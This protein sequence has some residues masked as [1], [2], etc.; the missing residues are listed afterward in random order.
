MYAIIAS[1]YVTVLVGIF[2][3][4]FLVTD[5]TPLHFSRTVRRLFWYLLSAIFCV[6][7]VM[8]L[9]HLDLESSRFFGLLLLSVVIASYA[10]DEIQN[11]YYLTPFPVK[12]ATDVP[13]T[14]EAQGKADYVSSLVA[15]INHRKGFTAGLSQVLARAAGSLSKRRTA[16]H[17][18]LAE[19]ETEELN[20]IVLNIN[21]SALAEVVSRP[22]MDM[23]TGSD[24]RLP[25]LHVLA[26][27]ALLDAL[28]KVGMRWRPMRQRWASN[29][30]LSTHGRELTRL[31]SYVDDGDDYQTLYKM[32]YNDFQGEAQRS[33]LQ[34]ISTQGQQ[35]LQE[36]HAVAPTAPPGVCLKVVSDIDDTLM[37]SG[38]TWPAGRDM[39]Y[40]RKCMYPGALALYSELD[41][42]YCTR[43][44]QCKRLEKKR[45]RQASGSLSDSDKMQS[46]A[47][48]E[49]GYLSKL[50]RSISSLRHSRRDTVDGEQVKRANSVE[51]IPEE[52]EDAL[53]RGFFGLFD[54]VDS[55]MGRHRHSRRPATPVTLDQRRSGHI[56]SRS[57]SNLPK[58]MQGSGILGTTAGEEVGLSGLPDR[59]SVVQLLDFGR[60]A[61]QLTTS[62]AGAFPD[63]EAR[64][65]ALSSVSRAFVGSLHHA[66]QAVLHP[67][68]SIQLLAGPQQDPW[69]A[70]AGD[71]SAQKATEEEDEEEP[72][73]LHQAG[74]H[75]AFLSARPESV[76][77]LTEAESFKNIFNPLLKRGELYC[78]PVL[79]LGSIHSGPTALLRFM[80]GNRPPRDNPRTLNTQLNAA[81][82]NR[83]LSRFK[84]FA[85]LYPE[86]CWVFL[87]DNGQGDVLCAEALNQILVTRDGQSRLL[88]AFIH[89]VV[90]LHQTVSTLR[91]PRSNK[92]SWLAT[93]RDRNIFL[94]RTHVGM[95]VQAHTL[96]LVDDIGLQRVVVSA[97]N[98]L[99]WA[100]ARYASQARINWD[101]VIQQLNKDIIAANDFLPDDKQAELIEL[102]SRETSSPR[103]SHHQSPTS[104][105]APIQ[106]PGP[107][108]AHSNPNST[109]DTPQGSSPP[110]SDTQASCQQPGAESAASAADAESRLSEPGGDTVC[111]LTTCSSGSQ[112]GTQL[113]IVKPQ[114][115]SS[116]K[117][118]FSGELGSM[119]RGKRSGRAAARQTS[120][121]LPDVTGRQSDHTIYDATGIRR[122]STAGRRIFGSSA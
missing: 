122:V 64:E 117:G 49:P 57:L 15:E 24:Q 53:D 93:W 110:E 54:E 35:A 119:G 27:A 25:E 89:R 103:D 17:Q 88:A 75:L 85:A 50:R 45:S 92:L 39:R 105:H 81:L 72:G 16:L 98:D 14:P 96:G 33:V 70:P 116:V 55:M 30:L 104:I 6:W 83:K 31:K 65:G 56:R 23:L 42:G 41:I 77:G 59:S 107:P 5:Q 87:G 112:S 67:L 113:P 1:T 86:C 43:L 91:S 19:A 99:R 47:S 28:Q 20:F 84:E 100:R 118:A 10:E 52:P 62:L 2:T 101:R 13:G 90:P 34:H 114:Q 7:S 60:G 36:L 46:A 8:I 106:A 115:G 74:V 102:N 51:D 66:C 69:E 18:V 4:V 48:G 108:A 82:A 22:T 109:S 95:A 121:E 80:L 58:D 120:E 61:G 32:V 9:K 78:S 63:R 97:C 38:G 37:C 94:H 44:Q 3:L 68:E 71:G 76:R 11:R 79:L 12:A 21:C 29:I 40:P 111:A 26:R 73:R